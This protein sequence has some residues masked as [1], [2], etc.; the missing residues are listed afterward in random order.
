M[1]FGSGQ[2]IKLLDVLYAR[3]TVWLDCKKAKVDEIFAQPIR[4]KYV[5]RTAGG[6]VVVI[7]A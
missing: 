3:A 1:T 4:H 7:S 2:A 6:S 5:R